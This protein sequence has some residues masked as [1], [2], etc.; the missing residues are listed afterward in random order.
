MSEPK[1]DESQPLAAPLC[2]AWLRDLWRQGRIN[3]SELLRLSLDAEHG[4]N[5]GPIQ[6]VAEGDYRETMVAMQEVHPRV[7]TATQR[8]LIAEFEKENS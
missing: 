5:S 6:Y 4:E 1:S 7:R 3:R 2:S 8:R